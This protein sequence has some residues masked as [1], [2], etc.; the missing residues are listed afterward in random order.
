[1]GRRDKA[2]QIVYV[3][4]PPER[5]R[6]VTPPSEVR[7][8]HRGFLPKRTPWKWG[9]DRSKFTE[10]Q[11]EEHNLTP[12]IKVSTG[13]HKWRWYYVPLTC[14]HKNSSCLCDLPSKNHDP[15]LILRKTA[16]KFQKKGILQGQEYLTS[17]TQNCQGNLTREVWE[18]IPAKRSLRRRHN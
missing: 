11:S 10:G 16:D 17:T 9:G 7:A 5:K 15:R 3:D 2:S 4:T 6:G 14:C 8:G 12:V 18:N 1:M 13:S